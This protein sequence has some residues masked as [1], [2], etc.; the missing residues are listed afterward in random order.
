MKNHPIVIL[1]LLLYGVSN[2][3]FAT[4]SNLAFG[5]EF[6]VT[7]IYTELISAQQVEQQ[8]LNNIWFKE[9]SKLLF[10]KSGIVS[11]VNN[12]AIQSQ[13]W[14]V[15]KQDKAIYLRLATATCGELVYRIEK[16]GN[17]LKWIDEKTNL[18]IKV[19]STPLDKTDR[20]VKIYNDLVGTWSSSIY[21]STVI[22]NLSD[23]E[24]H[25]I[26]SADF[27]YFLNEDGTFSKR[28]SINRKQESAIGGIWQLSE[29]GEKLILH[30]QKKDCTYETVVAD[31]KLLT[32]DEMVLGQSLATTDLE[33]QLCREKKTFFY[34][35]Q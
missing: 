29:D 7:K 24:G 6:G 11:I 4:T 22:D 14:R 15:E 10:S 30:L 13:T 33:K 17:T 26:I 1:I 8:L 35:K 20:I 21:P 12:N 3:L 16:E 18:A 34:N 28:I 9:N 25:S 32:M 23:G 31:I 5:G 27:K 19:N 2:S